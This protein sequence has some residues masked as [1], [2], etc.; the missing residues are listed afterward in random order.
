MGIILNERLA[1]DLNIA[2]EFSNE[3]ILAIMAIG[4]WWV[5]NDNKI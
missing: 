1:I 5:P 2:T 3:I 4:V